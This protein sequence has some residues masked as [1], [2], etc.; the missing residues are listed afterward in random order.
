LK[1]NLPPTRLRRLLLHVEDDP[2][3]RFLL[4]RALTKRGPLN[5][6]YQGLGTGEAA[7]EYLTQAVAGNVAM[8]ELVVLDVNMPGLD[9]FDVLEW[10]NEMTPHTMAVMLSS[11]ELLSDQLRARD[12]GSRGYFVKSATYSDFIEFL[13]GWNPLQLADDRAVVASV[14]GQPHRP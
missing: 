3:S 6:A 14:V 9:G 11:S 7:I 4:E 13:A 12:L 5:W 1:T 2:D 8:P 10:M